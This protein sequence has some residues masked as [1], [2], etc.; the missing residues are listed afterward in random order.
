[1]LNRSSKEV[2]LGFRIVVFML[3]GFPLP[4]A[5]VA[6][7]TLL[8]LNENAGGT[9]VPAAGAIV[10]C[11]SVSPHN[12]VPA[13]LDARPR[14]ALAKCPVSTP[15]TK[16]WFEVFAYVPVVGVEGTLTCT[17]T[18]QLLLAATLP[19]LKETEVAPA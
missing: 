3:R 17:L 11:A 6:V 4:A 19:L 14:L 2:L 5:S 8:A 1:M 15:P 13:E 12:P 10:H 18:T 16:R 9:L 7:V